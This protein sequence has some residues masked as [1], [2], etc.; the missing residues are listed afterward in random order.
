VHSGQQYE[1]FA[2]L[3]DLWVRAEDL[4][5]DWVSLFDHYRPQLG[6]ADGP[7]L[8]GLTSL[9]ALA[10]LTSSVRCAIMVAAPAWRHPALLAN[11]ISTIDHISKGRVE[12]GLGAGGGDRAYGQYGITQP[13]PAMRH[14]VLNEYCGVVRRLLS[15]PSVSFGGQH[16][17]LEEAELKPKPVQQRLPITI[18]AEGERKALRLVARWADGWNILAPGPESY[19][20]KRDVLEHWCGVEERDST[21]I[22]RSLTFRA[23]LSTTPERTRAKRRDYQQ[24]LGPD[25]PDLHEHLEAD[26]PQQLLE[27][28]GTYQDLGVTD[29]LLAL[30]PPLDLETME[31]FAAEVAPGLR[32]NQ[33]DHRRASPH[34]GGAA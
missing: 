30:R 19:R 24:L 6:G 12:L 1:D 28:L 27:Q 8:D 7:C 22:R 31:L 17:Q 5:F 25:H 34:G 15:E 16:F 2:A 26:T 4:G 3:A 33:G 29:F 13:P 11:A 20:R 10:Q 23:I 9:A 21:T 32:A 14:D 18:G